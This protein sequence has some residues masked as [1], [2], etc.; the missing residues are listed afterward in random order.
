MKRAV[1]PALWPYVA[2]AAVAKINHPGKN[3][4]PTPGYRPC[5]TE[6]APDGP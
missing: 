1:T 2:T 3:A 4:A 6:P 5:P